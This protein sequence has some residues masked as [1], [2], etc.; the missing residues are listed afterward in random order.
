MWP[1]T[2]IFLVEILGWKDNTMSWNSIWKICYQNFKS[3]WY[4]CFNMLHGKFYYTILFITIKFHLY[5]STSVKLTISV[6]PRVITTRHIYIY[7][8]LF[9]SSYRNLMKLV[10]LLNVVPMDLEKHLIKLS[11]V[12]I[13][14]IHVAMKN[15]V[16]N[17]HKH[18]VHHRVNTHSIVAFISKR[19]FN[20]YFKF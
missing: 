10:P 4:L 20:F 2:S 17:I 19:K 14:I 11:N 12:E 13:V 3:I 8:F 18:L 1:E 16:T 15:Y 9:Y 5:H 6:D 7:K